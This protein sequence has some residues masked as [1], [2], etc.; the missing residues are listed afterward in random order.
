LRRCNI[1]NFKR[2][3]GS[4]FF[5]VFAVVLFILSFFVDTRTQTGVGPDFFPKI[6]AGLLFALSLM[7][8]YTGIKNYRYQ[9][10][11]GQL[12]PPNEAKKSFKEWCLDNLD[13]VSGVLI[14]V[15]VIGIYFLG[16]LLPSIVYMFL[17]ILLYTTTKKRN[18]W[19][20]VIVSIV[21]PAAVY[22]LF[23]NYFHLMLP[24]GILG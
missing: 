17:Q 18:R 9:K 14:L 4:A 20:A 24:A 6:V 16:F 2:I 22:F 3:I 1:Q 11:N 21:V 5:A 8:L 15:Y 7:D 23:R 12:L 13:W 10:A 19:I